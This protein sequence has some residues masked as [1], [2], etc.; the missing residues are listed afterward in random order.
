MIELHG[1]IDPVKTLQGTMK[2]VAGDVYDVPPIYIQPE[3]QSK[4]V[5]PNLEQ[6]VVVP[7]DNY[8]GLSS[9][10]V[11]PVVLQAKSVQATKQNQYV[12]PDNGY[13]GLSIVEVKGFVIKEFTKVSVASD[14]YTVTLEDG[15]TINGSAEFDENGV[16]TSLTDDAGNQVV[17]YLSEPRVPISAERSDGTSVSISI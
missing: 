6:Q 1:R 4:V 12:Q 5:A 2:A 11:Q 16:P 10:T 8:D 17:F 13:V 3:L 9:V 14:S 15:T 7:D